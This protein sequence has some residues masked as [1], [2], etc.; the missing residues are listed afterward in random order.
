MF[1]MSLD[2]G[3]RDAFLEHV[4]DERL[5]RVIRALVGCDNLLVEF[6]IAV[7]GI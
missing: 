1:S 3:H 5:Q 4:D 6:A 7:R 2:F